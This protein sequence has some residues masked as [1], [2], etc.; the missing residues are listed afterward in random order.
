[1]EVFVWPGVLFAAASKMNLDDDLV[2]LWLEKRTAAVVGSLCVALFFLSALRIGSPLT[3]WVTAALFATGSI[4]PST[5]MQLLW[6]QTGV[7]FWM[8]IILL[9]ELR[10]GGRPGTTGTIIEAI[11]CSLMLACRPSA[12]TFLAPFGIWLLAHNYRRGICLIAIAVL[13][14]SPWA[15]MYLSIYH[16]PFGPSMAQLGDNWSLG[17]YLLPVLF[18][19]SRGLFVYQPWM[20]L[21]PL[22]FKRA[23]RNDTAHPLPSGWYALCFAII[24]CHIAL[25][26]SWGMWWGGYSWGSRLASEVV[27]VA[28]VLVVR[29]V[30]W[31]LRSSWGC[32]LLAAIGFAGF[33]MHYSYTHGMGYKWNIDKNIDRHPELLWDWRNPPFLYRGLGDLSSFP[34]DQRLRFD[35]GEFVGKGVESRGAET[36]GNSLDNNYSQRR[37]SDPVA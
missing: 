37:G 10:S 6:Q 13:A 26:G 11:A 4:V 19:P 31:L 21:L 15:V 7:A 32:L 35:E 2:Q 14:Y 36:A 29:P 33:A 34:L 24:A 20:I 30:G 1:M 3:A 12:M 9:I 8:L 25:I 28:G 18:S 5:L 16:S 17:G 27:V 22:L 23:I